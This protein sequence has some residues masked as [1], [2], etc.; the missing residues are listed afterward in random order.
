MIFQRAIDIIK[1]MKHQTKIRLQKI[2]FILLN[3]IV[4]CAGYISV[5]SFFML[6]WSIPIILVASLTIMFIPYS[7]FVYYK[8]NKLHIIIL[9]SIIVTIIYVSLNSSSIKRQYDIDACYDLGGRW[10]K[11]KDICEK[12]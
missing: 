7:I 2:L 6:Q 1:I 5:Q 11:E 10:I 3:F 8:L 12:F 4:L 9:V